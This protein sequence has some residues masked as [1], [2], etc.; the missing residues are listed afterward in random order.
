MPWLRTWLK[1]KKISNEEIKM[2]KTKEYTKQ[3]FNRTDYPVLASTRNANMGGSNVVRY[4]KEPISHKRELL[5]VTTQWFA[6]NRN[7]IISW[8]KKHN[9]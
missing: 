1:K 4:R 3:L 5:F 9:V 8:Y 2:L 6:G 7:D